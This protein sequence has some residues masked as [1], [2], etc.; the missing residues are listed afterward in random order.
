MKSRYYTATV[1]LSTKDWYVFRLEWKQIFYDPFTCG[2]VKNTWIN[3]V[4]VEFREEN[5]PFWPRIFHYI[6]I[7]LINRDIHEAVCNFDITR[8]L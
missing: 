5:K 2:M 4:D 3:C 8:Y 1:R 7:G 6:D